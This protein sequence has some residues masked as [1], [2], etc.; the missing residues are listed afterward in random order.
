MSNIKIPCPE[1]KVIRQLVKIQT[2]ATITPHLKPIK[3]KIYCVDARECN[4]NSCCKSCNSKCNWNKSKGKC[5]STIT[6]VLCIE[7]PISFDVDVDVSQGA[8]CCD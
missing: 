3:P 5:T 8:I 4:C 6:Q 1:E 2:E 7:I